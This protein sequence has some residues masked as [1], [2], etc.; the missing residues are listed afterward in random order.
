ML[1]PQTQQLFKSLAGSGYGDTLKKALRSAIA[2]VVDIRT[3]N[4][5]TD[6]EVAGRKVA[7]DVFDEMIIML[8]GKT[9]ENVD[10][11]IYE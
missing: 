5:A 2:D 4:N 3:I 1:S 10:N 8:N 9:K 11:F 6:G 7:A